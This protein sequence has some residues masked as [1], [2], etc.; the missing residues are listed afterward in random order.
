MKHNKN[1][2]ILV[3]TKT[4]N[5]KIN[6]ERNLFSVRCNLQGNFDKEISCKMNLYLQKFQCKTI[7]ATNPSTIL[8]S[9]ISL[10][11]ENGAKQL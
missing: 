2:S 5:L 7:K 1:M 11:F 4:W 8:Y 6:L 9:R 10:V 3:E